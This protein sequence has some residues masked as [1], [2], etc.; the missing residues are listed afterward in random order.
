MVAYYARRSSTGRAFGTE[1]AFAH[2]AELD[3]PV[4]GIAFC[5]GRHAHVRR[6][7]V[8]HDRPGELHLVAVDGAFDGRLA[9][10]RREVASEAGTLLREIE[11]VLGATARCRELHRPLPGKTCLR[12]PRGR[13][14]E[15]EEHD[16]RLPSG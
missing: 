8:F 16:G 12:R 13:E 7:A 1:G 14:H 3:R 9:V 6:L 4:D 2:R 10:L 15:C 5:S 11:R